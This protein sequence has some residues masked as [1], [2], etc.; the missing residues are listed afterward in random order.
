MTNQTLPAAATSN[1]AVIN[2][3]T[4]RAAGPT[5][6]IILLIGSCLPILGAVLLA[7]I[8]PTLSTV[9]KAS[10]GAEA[11]VPL[12]L[13][14]P[15]LFI[16]ILAPFAG[17]IADKVGRKRILISALTLGEPIGASLIAGVVLTGAGIRMATSPPKTGAL[18][19]QP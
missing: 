3:K 7:P 17:A 13:T 19:H 15:A 9:F 14:I 16:P 2:P 11:L 12:I 6:G 10:P 18:C 5:Q 4:G 1:E 8:L